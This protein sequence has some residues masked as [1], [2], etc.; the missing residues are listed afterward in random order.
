MNLN[1]KVSTLCGMEF[2]INQLE[3]DLPREQS[4]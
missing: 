1:K 4:W 3:T 2:A